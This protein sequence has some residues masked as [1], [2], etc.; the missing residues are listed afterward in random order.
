MSESYDL[1]WMGSAAPT[2]RQEILK[3][4]MT[5]QHAFGSI[6]QRIPEESE[7][8]A[9]EI[10]QEEEIQSPTQTQA[11]QDDLAPG[12]SALSFGFDE[13]FVYP[14]TEDDDLRD[15]AMSPDIH[16]TSVQ[17]HTSP[18]VARDAETLPS[19]AGIVLLHPDLAGASGPPH[20]AVLAASKVG[21]ATLSGLLRHEIGEV[22]SRHSWASRS[23]PADVL[24]LYRRRLRGPGWEEGLLAAAKA[25][26]SRLSKK[27]LRELADM[28]CEGQQAP[29]VLVI[30]G[31]TDETRQQ[32]PY[33]RVEVVEGAARVSF[34]EQP[35]ILT[36]I[37]SSFAAQ[38]R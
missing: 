25:V 21:R 35:V 33:G 28:A 4:L 37:I 20:M 17:A 16:D 18:A 19:V 27:K 36:S 31:S 38:L 12:E 34:E 2:N 7:Q 13:A 10:Q 24:A 32:P 23:P 1:S 26:S 11:E 8:R 3:R 30:E 29:A 22:G 15:T 14:A 6:T 5:G 9:I